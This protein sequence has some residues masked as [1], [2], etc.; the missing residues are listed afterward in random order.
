MESPLGGAPGGR[1]ANVSSL[2]SECPGYGDF[3]PFVQVLFTVKPW[4]SGRRVNPSDDKI[5]H[6]FHG[7]LKTRKHTAGRAE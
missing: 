2:V 7:F 3:I 4:L 6:G 5:R 1:A